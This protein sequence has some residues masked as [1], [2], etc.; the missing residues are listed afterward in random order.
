VLLAYGAA[1]IVW[2]SM[3]ELLVVH[4]RAAWVSAFV[5]LEEEKQSWKL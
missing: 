2:W 3:V 4:N 1:F 5:A